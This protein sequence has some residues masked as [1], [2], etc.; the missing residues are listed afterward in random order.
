[1][2]S[3][4]LQAQREQ[5]EDQA[6]RKPTLSLRAQVAIVIAGLSFLPNLITVLALFVPTYQ[7]LAEAPGPLWRTL[8]LW[9]LLP[10]LVSAGVGYVLSSHLLRPLTRLTQQI[11]VLQQRYGKQ[12]S[13]VRLN[14]AH[15]EPLETFALAMA[16]N[17]LLQ[18]VQLEQSRR[19]AFL[20]TLMHDLKTPLIATGHLLGVVRDSDSLPRE[21][22]ITLVEQV[23]R[24]NQS[25][26]SL[27]QKL[28]EAHRF[29]RENVP[30]RRRLCH[31]EDIVKVVVERS[32]TI[33]DT[34]DI[35][36]Q[37]R[38]VGQAQQ[39][40]VDPRE[41]ERALANLI[42]NAIRYARSQIRVEIYAS[43]VRIADDGPGLP[44]PLEQLAQPFNAQPVTIAGKKFTA[45]SGGLGMFIARRI[46]EGHG[47]RLTA[48]SSSDQGTVLLVYLGDEF[49]ANAKAETRSTNVR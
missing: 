18:Q 17:D 8:V 30:L 9:M 37:L 45:G 27:V 20:A 42:D 36:L 24:E 7:Q 39:V 1:M 23:L 31:L 32:R 22:R 12:L 33:A 13:K 21:E 41:L 3:R 16:F 11:H 49:S 26:I 5:P 29:E 44:M 35:R 40:F 6:R 25:L 43:M 28:V 34:K 48:E 38:T 2:L 10:M 46:I 4:S 47:G 14:V 15:H 19:N